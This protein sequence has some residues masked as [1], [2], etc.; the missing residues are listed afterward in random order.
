M[1]ELGSDN[2]AT[3][4]RK[5]S[6]FFLNDLPKLA[7][8]E[9]CIV[10]VPVAHYE[11]RRNSKFRLFKKR[12]SEHTLYELGECTVLLLEYQYRFPGEVVHFT[13]EENQVPSSTC[14]VHV[15]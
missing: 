9:G 3:D 15:F 14:T 7:E 5:S 1:A 12:K 2:L 11:K 13:P 4:Q 8:F 6:V 10:R